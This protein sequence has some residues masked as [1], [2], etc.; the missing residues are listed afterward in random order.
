MSDFTIREAVAGDAELILSFITK[1]AIYEKAENQV[2]ATPADIR[3]SLF[4]PNARAHALICLD[5]E[6]PIGYAVYFYNYST[7]LGR[8]GMYLEDVY[9]DP[10]HRNG[11]GGTFLLR[12][13][14]GLAVQ[15]GCGRLEWSV[16]DWNEPAIAFYRKMGAQPQS[17]WVIYRLDGDDLRAFAGQ[18]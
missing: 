4:G 14:A 18:S 11:G 7:W 8:N 15:Q 9:I 12:H 10:E 3:K 5:Q 17:E 16:L 1:L 2:V 6:V 13:L